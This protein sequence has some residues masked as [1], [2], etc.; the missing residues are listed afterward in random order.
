VREEAVRQIVDK[1][2]AFEQGLPVD[3]VV[4]RNRGY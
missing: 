3:D 1:I 2:T 4:D